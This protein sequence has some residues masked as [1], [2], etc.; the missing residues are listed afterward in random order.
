MIHSFIKIAYRN[1]IRQKGFSLINILGLS[2]GMACFV[3]ITL[4]VKYELGYDGFHERSGRIYRIVNDWGEESFVG[5]PSPLAPLLKENIPEI[6]NYV[7]ISRTSWGSKVLMS[8]GESNFHESRFYLADSS[9]FN[10]FSYPLVIGHPDEVLTEP[11][12]IVISEDMANKSN[13]QFQ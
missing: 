7:R 11:S 10:V 1:L 9:F 2:V 12:S 4:Y 3:L 8:A 5:T 13:Y 6:E